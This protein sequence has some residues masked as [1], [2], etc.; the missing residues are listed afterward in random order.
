[1]SGCCG[2]RWSR[3]SGVYAKCVQRAAYAK[4]VQRAAFKHTFSEAAMINIHLYAFL[5]SPAETILNLKEAFEIIQ[6]NRIS[7]K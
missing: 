2:G 7:L 5:L 1:M 3:S 6:L 4:C